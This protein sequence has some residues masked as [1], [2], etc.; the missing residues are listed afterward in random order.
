MQYTPR[1]YQAQCVAA[2]HDALRKYKS[3]LVVKA[4]GLGKTVTVSLAARDWLAQGPHYRVLLIAHRGELIWQSKEKLEAVC[5]ER[6]EV[7]MADMRADARGTLFG[8]GSRIFCASVQTLYRE[9][10]LRRYS[11]D[12]HWLIIVD[13][14]HHCTPRNKTYSAILDHFAARTQ[15]KI[16]GCTATPDRADE[17]ALGQVF[18]SVAFEYS[19]VDAIKDG[20]LV[21]ITQRMVHVEDLDLSG[22]GIGADGDLSGGQLDQIIAEEKMAHKIVWPTIDIAR[23]KPT[24]VFTPGV[25]AAHKVA[26]I[27]NRHASQLRADPS[28]YP[29]ATSA[30]DARLITAVAMDGKTDKD[31]RR[32]QLRAFKRGEFGVL[33]NCGIFLEGFDEP[34]IE[35]V[36]MARPTKSRSLYSQCVGRATRTIQRDGIGVDNFDTAA[37]RRQFIAASGK[38]SSVVIDF[39]GNSGRHKLVHSADILGGKE[40]DEC[41]ALAKKKAAA[42]SA[43]G[44]DSDT[45]EELEEARQELEEHHRRQRRKVIA[46]AIYSTQEVDPFDLFDVRAGRE[47]GYLKGKPATD[48]Q[49]AYLRR[50]GILNT[51]G[52]SL[53]K[54]KALIDQIIKRQADGLCSFKQ[55]KLLEAHGYPADCSQADAAKYIGEINQKI[56]QAGPGRLS[57]AS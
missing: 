21:P 17:E 40:S 16:L 46:E 15:A 51:Q 3:T 7:D 39:V 27:F 35:V 10:R 1:P 18:E 24:L 12:D 50:Q 11:A 22:V 45:L 30:D 44:L 57:R 14:A 28:R 38:P 53:H 2:I 54:A 6:V 29:W 13:E 41:V 55:A 19:V 43:E 49:I 31:E 36:A 32:A 25:A 33:V 8:Q 52:L 20:W 26:E 23:G 48:R 34:R 5:D 56:R 4:T 47:P 42:K 9:G 37:S